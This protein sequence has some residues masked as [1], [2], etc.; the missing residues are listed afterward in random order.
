VGNPDSSSP[1]STT[2]ERFTDRL[3][4]LHEYYLV[5]LATQSEVE[6]ISGERWELP[7]LADYLKRL[8]EDGPIFHRFGKGMPGYEYLLYLRH[9]GFPSPLLDWSASPSVAAYFAFRETSSK[10]A[11]VSIYA[12]C[13]FTGSGKGWDLTQPCIFGLGPAVR[14]HRRHFQQQSQYTVCVT[15]RGLASSYARHDQAFLANKDDQDDLWKFN[16]PASERPKVLEQLQLQNVSA[17]SLLG[18]EESLMETLAIRELFLG[19][20]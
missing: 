2:L 17:F 1:L 4:T 12:Y 10:A 5:L 6:A 7:S 19:S 3:L 16:I 20:S 18:S 15:S 9:H 13:E 8:Q 11:S 14:G